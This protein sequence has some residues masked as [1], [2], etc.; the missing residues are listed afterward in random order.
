MRLERSVV[1]ALTIGIVA[2]FAA[3]QDYGDRG[4]GFLT[5]DAAVS[6]SVVGFAGGQ[7]RTLNTEPTQSVPISSFDNPM[8]VEVGE[9]NVETTGQTDVVEAGWWHQ[10]L[11]GGEFIRFVVRTQDGHDFVP[12]GAKKNGSLIQAYTYEMGGDGNGLDFRNWVTDV[13]WD[14]LPI[15]YSYDG[16]Q[17]VFSDPTV[18][19]PFS[20][21]DWVSGTD[22]LHLGLALPGDGVNWIQASYKVT[23]VPAPASGVAFL[24]AGALAFRRRR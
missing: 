2:P 24:G 9:I 22:T 12:F 16:G 20:G 4:A 10:S 15:S 21:G 5:A 18:E 14:E 23:V 6:A 17:T 3:A 13:S 1:C 11:P 19:D 8:F 7:W